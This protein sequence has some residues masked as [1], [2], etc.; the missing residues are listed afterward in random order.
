MQIHA[1]LLLFFVGCPSHHSRDGKR[2]ARLGLIHHGLTKR[3]LAR[4]VQQSAEIAPSAH[5]GKTWGG[6]ENRPE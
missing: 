4:S 6:P 3:L 2:I 5:V 1:V